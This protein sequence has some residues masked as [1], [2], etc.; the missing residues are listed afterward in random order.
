MQNSGHKNDKNITSAPGTTANFN[1][2]DNGD[3]NYTTMTPLF[4]DELVKP[5]ILWLKNNLTNA[6]DFLVRF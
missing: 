1:T 5:T 6:P 2:D 4:M 3:D